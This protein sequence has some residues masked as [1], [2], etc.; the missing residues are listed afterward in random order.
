MRPPRR[1]PAPCHLR[2]HALPSSS[3]VKRFPRQAT[4]ELRSCLWND[5][6]CGNK[7][8]TMYLTQS[9]LSR[10]G[11]FLLVTN[12]LVTILKARPH[13]SFSSINAPPPK[14]NPSRTPEKGRRSNTTRIPVFLDAR[15]FFFQT[16]KMLL[17]P[18][19]W[20]DVAD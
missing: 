13:G 16:Q 19:F 10:P 12:L 11:V 3:R 8:R 15:L 2:S 20:L 14:R 9:G 5:S 1:S 4:Q 6:T 18:Q 17:F 7:L